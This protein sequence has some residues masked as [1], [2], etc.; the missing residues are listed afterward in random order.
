[1]GMKIKLC[2]ACSAG[3]H[4]SE[5]MQL[6]SFYRNHEHFFVSDYRSN[7]IALSEGNKVY[8]VKC[9]RRNPFYALINFFQSLRIFMQE[10][11]D[12]VIST[13]ADTAIAFCLL[14][15]LFGKKMIFIESL[16]RISSPSLSG[17]LIYPLADLFF[18][19]WPENK[20]FFPKG[21]D[22]GGVF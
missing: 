8:F 6:E 17:K 22:A 13:G 19:Q 7:A 21:I 18:I 1:M 5:M 20:K 15:K 12:V 16:A 4:L 9:P 11:P 3:G 14:A 2:L 10:K